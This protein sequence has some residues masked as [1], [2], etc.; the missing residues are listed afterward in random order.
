MLMREGESHELFN[1]PLF[2][3]S[4]SWILSTSGLSAGDRFYGTG[5]GTVW[6]DGYG[7]NC[8]SSHLPLARRAVTDMVLMCRSRWRENY[9]VWYRIQ[10][11]LRGDFHRDVQAAL[12]R[13]DAG[14]EDRL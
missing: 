1:D 9:Q 13:G 8:Q 5:F 14:D 6:P 3:E 4:Q 12:G 11:I 7:I 2:S 10:G